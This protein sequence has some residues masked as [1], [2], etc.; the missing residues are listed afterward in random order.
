MRT[1]IPILL[2]HSV[3]D[4]PPACDRRWTVSPADF[5]THVEAL[6]AS[7]R[8]TMTITDIAAALRGERP[9]P[10]RPVA[11]SFDDGYTDTYDA[12]TALVARDLVATIY[13]T[14]AEVGMTN[15]LSRR[16]LAE[17]AKETSL[18]IGAHAVRHRRLDELDDLAVA[19]EVRGSKGH[20]ECLLQASVQSFA[21][22][23]GAYDWAVRRAVIDAGYRSAAAVKNALSHDL[24]DPFAVARWTVTAGTPAARIAEVLDG[25]GVPLAWE[26]DRLRTRAYRAARRGRR[27]LTVSMGMRR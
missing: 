17:I 25:E 21:Y 19:A 9:L 26:H 14:T 15:R 16:Q 7:G 5:A 13:I 11:I 23:H 4:H 18:E 1:L 24:D 6:V 27:S 10:P 2:Y 12:L 20:L 8:T 22:P 3:S